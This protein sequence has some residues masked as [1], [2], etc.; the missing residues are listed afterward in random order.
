MKYNIS[1]HTLF[2]NLGGAHRSWRSI[3]THTLGGVVLEF[4]IHLDLQAYSS[5]NVCR[6]IMENEDTS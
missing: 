3:S 4:E 1:P 2:V 6:K 5:N